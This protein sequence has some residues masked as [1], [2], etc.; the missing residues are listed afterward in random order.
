[1]ARGALAAAALLLATLVAGPAQAF[2]QQRA[3]PA[4]EAAGPGGYSYTSALFAVTV[5]KSPAAPAVAAQPAPAPARRSG[6]LD[7]LDDTLSGLFGR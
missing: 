7:W 3:A 6:L 4:P 5:R 1:M 2:T